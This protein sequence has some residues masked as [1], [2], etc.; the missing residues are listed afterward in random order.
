MLGPLQQHALPQF[1]P[2]HIKRSQNG[3]RKKQPNSTL[4]DYMISIFQDR[5]SYM[6]S[7]QVN[8]NLFQTDLCLTNRQGSRFAL[9]QRAMYKDVHCESRLHKLK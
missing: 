6:D 3:H 2:D 9:I 8:E 5:L 7:R 4:S 1:P